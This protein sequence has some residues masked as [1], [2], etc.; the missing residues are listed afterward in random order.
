MPLRASQSCYGRI[1]RGRTPDDFRTLTDLPERKLVMVMG[2][3]GLAQLAGKTGWQCLQL[4]G[5]RMEYIVHKLAAGY[6]FKL[7]TWLGSSLSTVATWNRV[8]AVVS[9]TYPETTKAWRQHL[10][11]LEHTAFTEWHRQSGFD[12]SVVDE[13]GRSHPQFVTIERFV[14]SRQ[15]ALDLRAF[16]YFTVQLRDLF[17]GTGHT[18][19]EDGHDGVKEYIIPTAPLASLA[20]CQLTDLRVCQP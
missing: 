15:T 17:S 3:D 18:V 8:A 1:L 4:I 6:Q 2:R 10:P 19:T 7:A 13:A 20:N 5:Y 11:T 16:L 9:A 12:W 14:A